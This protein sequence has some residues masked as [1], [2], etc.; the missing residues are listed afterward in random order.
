MVDEKV[1]IAKENE[2]L[3]PTKENEKGI[4]TKENRNIDR[5]LEDELWD[6]NGKN[7]LTNSE[8]RLNVSLFL[9]SQIFSLF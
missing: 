2:K 6:Y 5:K 7:L 1:K 9:A 3:K 8:Y 4:P